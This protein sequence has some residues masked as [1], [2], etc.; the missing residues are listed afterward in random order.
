M[1]KYGASFPLTTTKQLNASQ[2]QQQHTR[3]TTTTESAIYVVCMR[4]R[5]RAIDRGCEDTHTQVDTS[6]HSRTACR[7][8]APLVN[9]E[10]KRCSAVHR[11]VKKNPRP[12]LLSLFQFL[13]NTGDTFAC[14]TASSDTRGIKVER[15][16]SCC[17]VRDLYKSGTGAEKRA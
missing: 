10:E 5:E 3:Q 12:R 13:V 2:R 1:C 15:T 16:C 14:L 17:R 6:I 8:A 9:K 7:T 11:G 4:T